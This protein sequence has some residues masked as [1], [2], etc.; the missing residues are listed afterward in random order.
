MIF[1]DKKTSKK[2]D[3][4]MVFEDAKNLTELDK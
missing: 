3:K 2:M 1:D 4:N